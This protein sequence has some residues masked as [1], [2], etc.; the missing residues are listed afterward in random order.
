MTRKLKPIE[1]PVQETVRDAVFSVA[2]PHEDGMYTTVGELVRQ[3]REMLLL[4]NEAIASND[5]VRMAADSMMREHKRRG[6]PRM[7]VR[8]DGTIVLR[9]QYAE[10]EDSTD[11]IEPLNTKGGAALPSL[12]TLRQEAERLG[13]DITDLGRRK[14]EI[15]KRLEQHTAPAKGSDEVRTTSPVHEVK[16][17]GR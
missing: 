14:R 7:V 16:L 5:L 13:V 17:P 4:A 10:E 6:F 8:A 12:K 3:A 15:M 9:I 2:V 11:S 1:I